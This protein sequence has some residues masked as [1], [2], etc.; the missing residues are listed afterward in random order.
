M[1]ARGRDS[2][3]CLTIAPVEVDTSRKYDGTDVPLPPVHLGK[4]TATLLPQ[5]S[6]VPRGTVT[7]GYYSIII[8]PPHHCAYVWNLVFPIGL[9]TAAIQ[10]PL[11]R[12]P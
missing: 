8:H 11:R 6:K 4:G 10:S 9:Q 3:S 2:T 7:W 5:Y 1:R 12:R